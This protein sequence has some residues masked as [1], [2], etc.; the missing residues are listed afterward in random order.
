MRSSIDGRSRAANGSSPA[1]EAA[2]AYRDLGFSPLPVRG[3]QPDAAL[4]RAASGDPGWRRLREAAASEGEIRRWYELDPAAGVGLV[5][6]GPGGLVVADFDAGPT[7][8]E[9]P[10]SIG[11]PT[12]PTARTAGGGLHVYLRSPEPVPT[13]RAEQL[14]WRGDLLADG[15]LVV[16]PPS[17]GYEWKIAPTG[18]GHGHVNQA[19]IVELESLIVPELDWA[20][21]LSKDR[22]PNHYLHD[23]VH[24]WVPDPPNDDELGEWDR[25][26]PFVRAALRRLGIR[27]REVGR[28]ESFLCVLPGH[29]LERHRSASLWADRRNRIV[30]HCWH[31]GQ[32]FT[33]AEVFAAQVSRQLRHLRGPEYAAWKLRL[34]IET[35][36][37]KPA[38]VLVLPLPADAARLVARTYAGWVSLFA[39]R[40]S[41]EYG[42][43]APFTK[44]FGAA[45]CGGMSEPR[46]LEARQWLVD[47]GLFISAGKSKHIPLW[48]PR[49]R[50]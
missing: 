38:P 11:L 3:K 37:R 29:D 31:L 28:G 15:A 39:C 14:P 50:R 46:F 17:R 42:T 35:G 5:T 16:A 49:E 22:E 33:L 2:L 43:P 19:A 36:F 12:T 48:L 47:R 40:W 10:A 45:W 32:V 8:L 7:G 25:F 26:Q 27:V 24:D 23:L 13:R 21:L 44:T 4:L 6:G 18:F 1:L 20:Q 41:R 30:Y 9:I 34:L